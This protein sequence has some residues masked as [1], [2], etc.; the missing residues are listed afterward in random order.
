MFLT[1]LKAA[2]LFGCA[3]WVYQKLYNSNQLSGIEFGK[4]LDNAN[5]FYLI[6]AFLLFWLNW[7]LEAVK[8]QKLM[9]R[10]EQLSLFRSQMSVF[11]G[12]TLSA[13]IPFRAG[14]FIGRIL[15][16]KS[17]YKIRAIPAAVVGNIM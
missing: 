10:T 13:F 16:L 8:W 17:K 6:L 14:S 9:A 11:A 3:Y 7:G 5:T 12:V 1:V 4:A 15:F 2:V